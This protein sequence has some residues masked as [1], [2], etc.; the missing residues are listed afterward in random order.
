LLLSEEFNSVKVGIFLGKRGQKITFELLKEESCC[1]ISENK[2]GLRERGESGFAEEFIARE[3]DNIIKSGWNP[4]T[5][6]K[7]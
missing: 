5:R 2:W 4:L 1:T 3:C 7:T 6:G